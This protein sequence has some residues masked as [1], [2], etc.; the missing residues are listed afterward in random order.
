M[1]LLLPQKYLKLTTFI[2]ETSNT[3]SFRKVFFSGLLS[4][5]AFLS[6]T[7]CYISKQYI[8]LEQGLKIFPLNRLF[9]PGGSDSK[10]SDCNAGDMGFSLWVGKIPLRRE[11]QPTPVFLP[12]EFH[13]HRSLVGY[14]P[15][16]QKESDMT[17]Q[18]TL[19]L[20]LV[21]INKMFL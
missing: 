9:F 18:H 13:A 11:W 19:S 15:W 12:G 1:S 14:S 3:Q 2:S 16:G 17:E 6:S 5:V 7:K 20:S 8:S 10:E 4:F 21:R